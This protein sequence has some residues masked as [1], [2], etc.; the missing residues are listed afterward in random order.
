MKRLNSLRGGE[1]AGDA[2]KAMSDVLAQ[3]RQIRRH[4]VL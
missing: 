3:Y 1:A 4:I 2:P